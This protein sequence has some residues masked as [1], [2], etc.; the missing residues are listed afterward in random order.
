M[1]RHFAGVSLLFFAGLFPG[2]SHAQLKVTEIMYDVPGAN[3]G[4]QWIEISNRG[5][6]LVDLNQKDIRLFDA[7]GNHLLKPVQGSTV[8]GSNDVVVI[9]QN[10][11]QFLIDW[12]TFSGRLLKS[13]FSLTAKGDIGIVQIDGRQLTMTSYSSDNGAKGDGNSLQYSSKSSSLVSGAPTPGVFPSTPP[14]P[15]AA[16]TK[17]LKDKAGSNKQSTSVRK[18]SSAAHSKTTNSKSTYGKGIVAP[19][20]T[21]D[22]AASGAPFIFPILPIPN[23]S[24]F[25]SVWFAVFLGLLAFSGFSLILIQKQSQARSTLYG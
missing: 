10:P 18:K 19:D 24:L 25:S 23:L 3:T 5:D 8:L 4:H 22:A 14:A 17:P 16:I 12:P 9:A 7:S 6:S 2:V 15:L 11:T 20:A 21:A 1:S 13:S